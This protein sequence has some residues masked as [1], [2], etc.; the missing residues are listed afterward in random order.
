MRRG[1]KGDI[2]W[3]LLGYKTEDP[4]NLLLFINGPN[5]EINTWSDLSVRSFIW[6]RM[7]LPA[8]WNQK[9]TNKSWNVSQLWSNLWL[10]G[11]SIK[12]SPALLINKKCHCHQWF[13]AFIREWR[14]PKLG[15]RGCCHRPW[16]LLRSRK[17]CK[18]KGELGKETGPR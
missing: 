8:P 7:R 15:S 17:E 1:N 4:E 11:E 12:I 2:S 3:I 16:W 9:D 14:L 10:W 18:K 5:S 13:L 6:S